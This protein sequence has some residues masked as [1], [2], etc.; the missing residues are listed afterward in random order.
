MSETIPTPSLFDP[1][2]DHERWLPRLLRLV[3]EQTDLVMS[4]DRLSQLQSRA[5]AEGDPSGALEILAQRDP[6]VERMIEISRQ[7][8]PYV[9]ESSGS[10]A[11]VRSLPPEPRGALQRRLSR[12]SEQLAAIAQ[13]DHADKGALESM[14]AKVATELAGVA[15]GRGV[16]S[17][18][19]ASGGSPQ[20]QDRSA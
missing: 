7:L 20:M 2:P 10:P 8:Q 6:L 14:R 11:P 9:S 5:V 18:Y 19:Q 12:L 15:T 1:G 13:R 3:D 16:A 4:L 17:A